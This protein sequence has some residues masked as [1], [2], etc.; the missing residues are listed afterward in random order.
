MF[1]AAV[2]PRSEK[3]QE[4]AT[5]CDADTNIAPTHRNITNM[6]GIKR[7][8][9]GST[10][11]EVKAKSKKVKTEK[12]TSKREPK[13]EVKPVKK[14]KK[15]KE[16]SSEELEESDTSEQ[17]NGFYGF[18][19]ADGA[20]V[21]MG[22]AD[23]GEEAGEQPVESNGKA[24]SKKPTSDAAESK[25][26]GIGGRFSQLPRSKPLANWVRSKQLT[27]SARETEGHGQGAKGCEA[28][29]RHHRTLQ[30]ALGAA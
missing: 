29:R 2:G 7:K 18:S 1:S 12:P 6:A 11:P 23:S 30:E 25:L 17:E 28:E 22:D 14:S 13:Q 10:A 21:D 19:A 26:A 24:P 9:A 15:A 5:F 4:V 3:V 20:D 27:R 8:S 16:E